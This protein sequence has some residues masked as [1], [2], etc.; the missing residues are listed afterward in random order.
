MFSRYAVRIPSSHR[1]YLRVALLLAVLL[2]LTPRADAQ[3]PASIVGSWRMDW[4]YTKFVSDKYYGILRVTQDGTKYVGKITLLRGYG[5]PLIM[6]A[7]I[8]ISGNTVQ[9][10]CQKPEGETTWNPDH[11]YLTL[12]GNVMKGY[13]VDD[14]NSQGPVAVF[15]RL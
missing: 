13:S 2:C 11:F 15:E 6:D 4:Q 12:T 3:Q 8:K 9:I 1:I 10:D 14:A 5:N 7:E